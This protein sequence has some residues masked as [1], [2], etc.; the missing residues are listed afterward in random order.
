[1]APAR[2]LRPA[3]RL[4]R[5]EA[6]TAARIQVGGGAVNAQRRLQ[7][8]GAASDA[9]ALYT[10]RPVDGSLRHLLSE[11]IGADA[12]FDDGTVLVPADV[13]GVRSILRLA[14]ENHLP[15]R[16]T[17]G[18]TVAGRA[19]V[20]GAVLSLQR[21]ANL[22]VD[23]EAG[24]ARAEAGAS[25]GDLERALG[26]VAMAVPGLGPH[27]RSRHAG[28][29]VARGDVPRRSLLSLEAVLPGGEVVRL[30][31]PVLKD[32]VGYDLVGVMLG[33]EGRVAAVTAVSLRLVPAGAGAVPGLEAR[34]AHSVEELLA[35][36]DP[37]GILV[38]S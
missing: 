1:M 32:V 15:L 25:L 33:S 8:S 24:I 11:A 7:T 26:A 34:G 9:L 28:S 16:V 18:G 21:L 31:A 2:G 36:F 13:E 19:P 20:G 27:S 37:E 38:G 12:L 10:H 23:A 30:G 5:R 35:V 29:L 22:G 6:T 3:S 14:A 4:E 17:S